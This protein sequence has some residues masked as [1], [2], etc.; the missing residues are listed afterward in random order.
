[1]KRQRFSAETLSKA[2]RLSSLDAASFD[3]G[4]PLSGTPREERR[5]N[6]PAG[7]KTSRRKI[8]LAALGQLRRRIYL[9]QFTDQ[10]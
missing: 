6:P 9:L 10:R 5:G 4:A 7:N 2:A 1:M 8:T 3:I